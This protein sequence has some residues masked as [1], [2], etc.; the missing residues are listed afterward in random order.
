MKKVVV[1]YEVID[2]KDRW[3]GGYSIKLDRPDTTALEM[4]IYNANQSRGTVYAIYENG[5]REEVYNHL[6]RNAR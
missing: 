5:D 1:S 6:K 3:M 4:A 2:D